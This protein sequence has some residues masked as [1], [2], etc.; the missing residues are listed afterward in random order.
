[1]VDLNIA[2]HI[3]EAVLRRWALHPERS[4]L[5][6][7][8]GLLTGCWV[9]RDRRPAD[10]VDFLAMYAF[11]AARPV[12]QFRE[13]LRTAP[14]AVTADGTDPPCD[15]VLFDVEQIQSTT[16]FEETDFP[17]IRLTVPASVESHHDLLQID[18]AFNDPV[19][20]GT[21]EL[22]FPLADGTTARLA[23]PG[24]EAGFGWKL[25]GL[26]EK[27]D[28]TWRAKDLADLWLIGRHAGLN[29]DRLSEAVRIAFASRD[30]PLWRLDRLISGQFG[31]SGSSRRSWRRWR[32]RHP[33]AELPA[34]LQTVVDDLAVL[35]KPHW[36]KWRGGDRPLW[37][38]R[39]TL[40][41]ML[42]LVDEEPDFQAYRWPGGETA[43]AY[44]RQSSDMFPDPVQA[45]TRTLFRSRQLRREARGITFD[46]AGQLVA[47]P[48]PKF[49]H[50]DPQRPDVIRDALAI[51]KLDGSLVFPTPAGDGWTWRTRRRPSE[52]SEAAG[53]FAE[54]SAGDYSELVNHC[55]ASG[56]TPLFE[57]CSRSRWIVLDHPVDR[58]VLTGV[59]RNEGGAFLGRAELEQLAGTAGIELVRSF[60]IVTDPEAWLED[61]RQWTHCEGCVL[62]SRDGRLFKAKTPRYRWLH[63][64][65]EGPGRDRARWALVL[66]GAAAEL[67]H[68]SAGRGV[69]L[70]DY[71]AA[72]NRALEAATRRIGEIVGSLPGSVPDRSPAARKA[73]A[74]RIAGRSRLEQRLIFGVFD[75]QDAATLLRKAVRDSCENETRF[76]QV[77]ELVDGPSLGDG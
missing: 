8:G 18:V 74:A 34:D 31:S 53:R 60:G 73:L 26:V 58:L 25:H 52:I 24:P 38:D 62:L 30:A 68:S 46:G 32:N 17:G 69:W 64:A 27:S 3:Q 42:E 71:V 10:D 16:I 11:D 43:I 48:Y 35:V 21:V 44:D 6:L 63:R 56:W 45:A 19:P 72:L 47:R 7:R 4:T 59:R 41:E 33:E 12:R 1:M 37:P 70:D 23:A 50:V 49:F 15:G 76:L 39:P 65:V 66:D 67:C 20:N 75:N 40:R 14:A 2:R 61:L 77:R 51:E 55:L 9:G 36:E 54:Q 57:W 5:V 22:K 13:A 28:G 29:P